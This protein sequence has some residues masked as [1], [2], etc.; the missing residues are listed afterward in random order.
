MGRS[1]LASLV[2]LIFGIWF[3]WWLNTDGLV[4]YNEA[5]N[6]LGCALFLWGLWFFSSS[7]GAQK[8]TEIPSTNP[9]LKESRGREGGHNRDV[10]PPNYMEQQQFVSPYYV[11]SL[12]SS[13]FQMTQFCMKNG[14][15]KKD[16]PWVL[17]FSNYPNLYCEWVVWKRWEEKKKKED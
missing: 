1:I 2:K 6:A 16:V 8:D 4:S 9:H 10:T 3:V 13:L 14:S 7:L 17:T 5:H 12:G 11:C 15:Y